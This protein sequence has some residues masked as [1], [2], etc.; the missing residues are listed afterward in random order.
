MGPGDPNP[1]GGRSFSLDLTHNFPSDSEVNVCAA[2]FLDIS[3]SSIWVG[4]M[5]N[6]MSAEFIRNLKE[7]FTRVRDIYEQDLR[8]VRTDNDPCFTDVK[9]GPARNTVELDT[10]LRSLPVAQSVRFTH[11]SAEYQAL[12]PVEC[13]VR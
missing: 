12:N 1:P 5:K 10:C 13:A 11:S 7:N 8:D 9:A 2:V 4:Q 6:M 3:T